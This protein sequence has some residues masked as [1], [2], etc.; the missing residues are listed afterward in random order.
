MTSTA[1]LACENRAQ[2]EDNPTAEAAAG[3]DEG[4]AD[5][6][7]LTPVPNETVRCAIS[8]G[9]R[10]T[11]VSLPDGGADRLRIIKHGAVGLAISQAVAASGSAGAI[12]RVVRAAAQQVVERANLQALRPG[13]C[14]VVGTEGM[15]KAVITFGGGGRTTTNIAQLRSATEAFASSWVSTSR[16]GRPSIG[17]EH[18][19]ISS[20][21]L[22]AVLE[23]LG[24]GEIS[25]EA[26][27]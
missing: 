20:A 18:M 3:A 16:E 7:P 17:I 9:P 19:L 6:V 13:R 22:A 12:A 5:R 11:T 27:R 24:A 23:A 4:R 8:I 2:S 25:A 14:G 26:G 15:A 10:L 21:V 1:A